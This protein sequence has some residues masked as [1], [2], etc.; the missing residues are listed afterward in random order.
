LVSPPILDG[1]CFNSVGEFALCPL[2]VEL[3][4]AYHDKKNGIDTIM[5]QMQQNDDKKE[6]LQFIQNNWE[7]CQQ[8]IKDPLSITSW[9]NFD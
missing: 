5:S 2:F 9:F 3:R 1:K 7:L 8:L 4:I 6:F